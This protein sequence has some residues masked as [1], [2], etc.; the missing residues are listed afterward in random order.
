M[1]VGEN[2]ITRRLALVGA[3]ALVSG[4][5]QVV[6]TESGR[7]VR[8]NKVTG[9]VDEVVDGRLVRAQT[10]EE[11][12]RERASRSPDE[13]QMAA[14][15]NWEPITLPIDGGTQVQLSTKYDVNMLYI[16]RAEKDW[17]RQ[18]GRSFASIV[19]SLSDVDGFEVASATIPLAE[20]VGLV[21]SDPNITNALEHRGR[22]AMSADQYRQLVGYTV[23]WSGFGP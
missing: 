8:L 17:R 20:M 14:R 2:M 11:I 18:P 21:G 23:T 1:V 19:L 15:R 4:C 6:Q 13:I 22:I 9:E 16:L 12:E 3:T 7:I 10:P 5:Y